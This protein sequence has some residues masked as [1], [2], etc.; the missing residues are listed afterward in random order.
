LHFQLI[1][2]RKRAKMPVK[3]PGFARIAPGFPPNPSENSAEKRHIL[4]E[5]SKFSGFS[6]P[7]S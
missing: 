4:A 2:A 5:L 3:S 7:R 6:L 1:E